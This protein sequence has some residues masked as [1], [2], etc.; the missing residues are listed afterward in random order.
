VW[1]TDV[2]TGSG[3]FQILGASAGDQS[4]FS[5]S[6]AG[7][8]NGD[9]LVDLIIGAQGAIRNSLNMTGQ[10]YVVFGSTSL[11]QINLADIAQGNGGFAIKTNYYY[12][13]LGYSVSS[14]GDFNGD[15]L[16]DLIVS[17]PGERLVNGIIEPA[18]AYLIYGRTATTAIDLSALT[19]DDGFVLYGATGGYNGGDG[20]GTAVSAAGDINGDG[21]ADLLVRAPF[22]AS[23]SNSVATGRAY[24]IFGRNTATDTGMVADQMGT[25]GDNSLSDGGTSQTL[26]G[27]S[28]NDT[29]SATAASVLFGGSG[30]DR[31]EIGQAMITALQSPFGSGGNVDKLAR[32]DGGTGI[33]TLALTGSG[34]TLDLTQVANLAASNPEVINRID[35]IEKIELTGSGDNTLKLTVFDLMDLSN[36][37]LFQTTGRQQL[38]V[39]GNAGDK[40]DLADGSGTTGWTQA[41]NPVSIDSLSYVVW[42]HSTAL[43]TLYVQSD[44]LVV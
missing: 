2:Q 5:V 33:D 25:T 23:T 7:D 34:L 9:G 13:Y 42:N 26:V 18:R 43:A 27:N 44:V 12:A 3:G 24:V 30:N 38:M 19:S 35:S 32:M 21:L 39:N 40:V 14:A 8:V 41:A 20:A 28:G 15:G 10:A 4:G 16:A 36:A 6:A 29:L 22:Y 1:L 37:N 31:F 17:A 11:S